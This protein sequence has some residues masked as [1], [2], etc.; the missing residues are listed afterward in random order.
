MTSKIVFVLLLLI[1][2]ITCVH[3]REVDN[4]QSENPAVNESHTN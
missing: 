3:I 4:H 1:L 2:G